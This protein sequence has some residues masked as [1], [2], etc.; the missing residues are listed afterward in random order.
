MPEVEFINGNWTIYGNGYR[1]SLSRNLRYM[2]VKT[3][4]QLWGIKVTE[5]NKVISTEYEHYQYLVY[6]YCVYDKE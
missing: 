5:L 4:G 6:L 1:Y 3:K 2:Y